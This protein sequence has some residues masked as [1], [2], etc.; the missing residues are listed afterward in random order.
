MA[1]VLLTNVCN[2]RCPY[3]FAVNEIKKGQKDNS[4]KELSLK[5]LKIILDFLEK[6][7]GKTIRLMGGEPTLHS[8]FKQ[9][10]DY[11][12]S[13]GFT[14]HLFTNGLF[15]NKITN[16]LAK[17]GQNIKY[18][19]NINSPNMYSFKRWN[20]ILNNLKVLTPFKNCL[21]G[22][23]IWRE[24]FNI[25]YLIELANKYPVKVIML[26]IANPIISQSNKYVSLNS[27]LSLAKNLV[28]EIKKTDKNKIK[29]GLGCGFSKKMFTEKQIE[30]LKRYNVVNLNWGCDGNSG[31]FDIDIDL[32]IFRCFPL[33]SW[34][35][36]KLSDFKDSEEIENYFSRLMQE[37]QSH[38]SDIDFIHQGPCF[39]YLLSKNL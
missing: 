29:I 16:F 5:N 19:F 6:S 33:S 15:S 4:S 11:I 3:C 24:N 31:R 9:C 18:S 25:D 30:V 1:N 13:R 32:S 38:N 27:Y 22:S 12:F 34:R 7:N 20:M 35:T 14:A 26:R 23:I 2:Q 37:Y 10:I 8:K 28:R 36:K 17:K 39:S 21:I